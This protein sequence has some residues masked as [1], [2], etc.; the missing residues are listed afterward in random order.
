MNDNNITLQGT[1]AETLV[2]LSEQGFNVPKVYYF[3]VQQWRSSPEAVL[4]E[5]EKAFAGVD[6][7]AV[8]SSSRAED[9]SENSMAGAFESVLNVPR[10]ER[11]ALAAA[12]SRV[13]RC[14][15]CCDSISKVV[16]TILI[17]HIRSSSYIKLN[18][19][20]LTNFTNNMV[21]NPCIC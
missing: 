6:L 7:L 18:C 3:S 2:L 20:F 5:I 4:G 9:T 13:I 11:H 17:S 12:I 19:I 1:K 15:K 21:S 8:R 16:N 10:E 14:F